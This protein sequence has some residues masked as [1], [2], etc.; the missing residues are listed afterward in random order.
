MNKEINNKIALCNII[1]PVAITATT[2]SDIIDTKGF[3]SLSVVVAMGA[4]TFTTSNY[5]TCKLQESDT[6]TG[7]DFTDVASADLIG[8]FLVYNAE[9]DG[10]DQNSV[11]KVGYRGT[12]RYVRLVATETG[13]FSSVISATAILSDA[14]SDVASNVAITATA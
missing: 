12:K 13:T 1:D 5:L 8:S 2:T 14:R 10:I 4:G 3:E 7:T 9:S 6:T 11:Q